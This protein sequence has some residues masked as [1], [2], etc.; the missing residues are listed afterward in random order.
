MVVVKFALAVLRTLV[1]YP[2]SCL[3]PRKKNLWLFGAP[4]G[5]F[6]DNSKYLLLYTQLYA[7]GLHAVW[8][9]STEEQC[10]RLRAEG[11]PAYRRR[12]LQGIWLRLRAKVYIYSAYL[13][14]I[15][16]S[17]AGGAF[18]VNLWH[19]V[20]VKKIEFLIESG[21]LAAT[22]DTSPFNINRL[23]KADH[24]L[25]PDL[26][27]AP[28]WLMARHF[29][30]AFRIG[31][32]RCVMAG[33]PRNAVANDT[34]VLQLA[35]RFGDYADFER[36]RR[37]HGQVLLY[38]PTWRDSKDASI[39]TA[40]VDLNELNGI[41]R[42]RN[43][44]LYIKAHPNEAFSLDDGTYTNIAVWPRG[45]DI[46]PALKK[47]DVLVT[48]YSSIYYDFIAISVGRVWLYIYDYRQYVTGSRDLAFPYLENVSGRVLSNWDDFKDAVLTDNGACKVDEKREQ[49]V[50]RFWGGTD[51][52]PAVIVDRIC[53]DVGLAP[54][55]D[56]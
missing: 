54:Q 11:V 41:L 13:S 24:F 52:T 55:A 40:L 12:S 36:I 37:E 19:G 17:L 51:V 39:A 43:S 14:E 16:Y 8:I 3:M 50:A 49:L 25:R 35:L 38:M 1:L 29:S 2:A 20:G 22:F 28:S 34:R 26:M 6:Y 5:E 48:D 23:L 7:P 47:V 31:L 15:G 10:A 46:Y 42:A 44:F 4:R 18:K 21:P 45:L 30:K 53:V 56:C 32:D 9:G 27:L 33:Y